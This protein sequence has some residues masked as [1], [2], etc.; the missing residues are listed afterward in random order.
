MLENICF[1]LSRRMQSIIDSIDIDVLNQFKSNQNLFSAS[2]QIN[3]NSKKKS[4][5]APDIQ[6]QLSLLYS[7][8]IYH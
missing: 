1:G 4:V 6:S 3:V 5:C 7:L 8:F 2:L